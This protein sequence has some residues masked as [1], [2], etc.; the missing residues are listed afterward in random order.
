MDSLFSNSTTAS[1]GGGMQS[2]DSCTVD[3]C[4]ISTSQY[5]YRI[6]IVAN[7]LFVGLLGLSLV[8]FIATYLFTRKS[9]FTMAFLVAMVLGLITEIIGYI[10]RIMS[11]QNQWSQNL[12]LV[13]ICC[14][15]IGPA[16][17]SAGIY[18]CLRHIVVLLGEEYSRIAPAWYT[19]IVSQLLLV[20][21]RRHDPSNRTGQFSLYIRDCNMLRSIKC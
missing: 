5:Q 6:S 8:L 7:A 3:T 20:M 11:W 1:G 10:G 17:L 16:F 4:A 18:L 15:T 14:L 19:R 9:Q 13:Q 12:Y 2:M 21:L